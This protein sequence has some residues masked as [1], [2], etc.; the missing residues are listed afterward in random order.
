MGSQFAI[1]VKNIYQNQFLLGISIVTVI[2]S[3]DKVTIRV[4]GGYETL[5]KHVEL[6]AKQAQR[7]IL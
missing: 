7:H 1:P 4:G 2:N 5:K 3:G 6:N